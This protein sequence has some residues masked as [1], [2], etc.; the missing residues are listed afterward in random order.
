VISLAQTKQLSKSQIY[1]L[2]KREETKEKILDALK[3]EKGNYLSLGKLAE[4]TGRDYYTIKDIA[5]E[6]IQEGKM[7]C[8]R[9]NL[10]TRIYLCYL[11]EDMESLV[12]VE[13]LIAYK[14]KQAMEVTV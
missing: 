13:K 12:E 2:K 6:L 3:K 10:P 5:E 11:P 14:A 9:A 1:W 7:A 4:K 8:K